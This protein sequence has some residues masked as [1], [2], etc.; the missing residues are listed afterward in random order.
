MT[1]GSVQRVTQR[2]KCIHTESFHPMG[3]VNLH[4]SVHESVESVCD[5]NY[6]QMMLRVNIFFIQTRSGENLFVA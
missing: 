1:Y 6:Y 2:L 3:C 5:Y 4:H